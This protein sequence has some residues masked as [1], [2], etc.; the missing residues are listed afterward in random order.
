MSDDRFC[1]HCEVVLELHSFPDDPTPEDCEHA[2]N[3]ADLMA[4]FFGAFR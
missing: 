4:G 3:K 1:E 2:G